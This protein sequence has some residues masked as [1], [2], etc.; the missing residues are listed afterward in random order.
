MIAMAAMTARAMPPPTL[1][2][3]I[4]ADLWQ[5]SFEWVRKRTG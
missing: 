2:E 5:T 3:E 1:S 4:P